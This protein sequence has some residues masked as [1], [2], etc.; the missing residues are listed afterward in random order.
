MRN[1]NPPAFPVHGM[2][3]RDYFA[4]LALPE[5]VREALDLDHKS[6]AATAEHAYLIAD[7]MLQARREQSE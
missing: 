7:A 5:L 6:W 2:D 4:A 3:L 1:H